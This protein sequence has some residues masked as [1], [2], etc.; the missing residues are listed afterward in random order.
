MQEI[1]VEV[2]IGMFLLL[3]FAFVVFTLYLTITT[4]K[5]SKP[6]IVGKILWWHGFGW[7]IMMI[8]T[9]V[10]SAIIIM[11]KFMYRTLGL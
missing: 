7:M 5:G 4:D 9:C 11:S 8:F 3:Y 6:D 10:G 2:L 1:I